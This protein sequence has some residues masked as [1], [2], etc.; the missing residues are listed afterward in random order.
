MSFKTLFYASFI[1]LLLAGCGKSSD[2]DLPVLEA[3]YSSNPELKEI[4]SSD[5]KEDVKV[6]TAEKKVKKK[7]TPKKKK[8]KTATFSS[9][10]SFTGGKSSDGLDMHKIRASA[11]SA[12]T[13][14]VFESYL[15]NVD[16]NRPTTQANNSGNYLITYDSEAR[17]ITALINGYRAFSALTG[18]KTASFP[19]GSMIKNIKLLPYMD[20]SGYKFTINIKEDAQVKVFELKNPGRIVVDIFKIY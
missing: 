19:A 13:R 11:N 5:K 8:V 16:K 12:K 3:D 18:V 6:K 20:D 4:L 15:W 14:L 17:T 1:V 2:I 9:T 10:Q 7:S